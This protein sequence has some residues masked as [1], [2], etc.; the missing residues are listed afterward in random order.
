MSS[1][2]VMAALRRSTASVMPRSRYGEWSWSSDGDKKLDASAPPVTPRSAR[3]RARI[4][5]TLASVRSLSTRAGSGLGKLQREFI[6]VALLQAVFAFSAVKLT[7]LPDQSRQSAGRHN[8]RQRLPA[9]GTSHTNWWRLHSETSRPGKETLAA[10]IP[11]CRQNRAASRLLPG[12]PRSCS[13][14]PVDG[15]PAGPRPLYQG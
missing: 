9:V 14:L 7:L 1:R 6:Y 2:L 3:R 12:L 15:S 13:Q 10:Q 11:L 5:E 8:R 4:G